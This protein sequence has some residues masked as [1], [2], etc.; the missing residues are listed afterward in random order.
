[1]LAGAPIPPDLVAGV[2]AVTGGD[3]RAPVGHDR[4]PAGHRRHRARAPSG[5]WGAIRPGGPSPAAPWS[6]PR[7][8]TRPHR[9]PTA[10]WGELLVH[11]PWMFDGYDAAWSADADTWI[12]LDGRRY[13]RTGD[14]GYLHDGLVFHLGPPQ[15]RPRHRRR[16]RWPA[17]PS[18]S[19]SRT[20]LGTVRWPPSASAR[21][22]AQVVCLVVDGDGGLDVAGRGTAQRGARRRPRPGG[23][24][25]RG[26][27][28]RR[29]PTRVEDRPDRAGRRPPAGSWPG[30]EGPRHRRLEPPRGRRRPAAAARGDVVTCFQRRPSGTGAADVLGD[31]RDSTRRPCG[32]RRPR[33]RRPPRRPR[34]PPTGV[35]RCLRG[36]R[37]GHRARRGCRRLVWAP[38][39]RVV[40]IGRLRR[41]ARRSAPGP[42]RPATPAAT[43][44]PTPRRWPSAWCSE[45]SSVPTVV[46]RP[47]LV[48]GP[49]DTQL[50]RSDRRHGPA[51]AGWPCPTT[52]G[53]SSTPPTSTTPPLRWWPDSTAR[54]LRRGVGRPWVVTGDDPRPL[55]ELVEGILRAAGLDPLVRSVPAPV[56][57]AV[58]RVLGRAG[59]G[60]E[61]PLTH[62]ARPPAVGGPLVRPARHPAGP[63]LA[64]RG[65]R[66]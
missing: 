16:A 44:T 55:L 21:P 66:R 9:C 49:G 26:P 63:P 3:V 36:Q 48:W 59:R 43:P 8:T 17:W 52:D 13:H 46:L 60:D 62:F 37:G 47:H 31:V 53:R 30:G 24:R 10:T 29:P 6:S 54:R 11:A 42:G 41:P 20:A 58:G 23:R 1:M 57:S 61:P 14:V 25:P 4:V 64:S 45:Q 27:P 5:R 7:S 34:C 39:A 40:T 12:V 2:R 15:P 33:R 35:G 22:G 50:D 19:P 38:G 65:R 32:G 18:R 56:A 51:R 28:A